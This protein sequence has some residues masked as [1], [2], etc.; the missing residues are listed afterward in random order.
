MKYTKE[1][2]YNGMQFKILSIWTVSDIDI[3]GNR[4]TVSSASNWE[5]KSLAELLHNFNTNFW[6]VI[7]YKEPVSVSYS[8]Y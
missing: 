5:G 2:I 4:C 7:N 8:I 3:E 6:E 1:N